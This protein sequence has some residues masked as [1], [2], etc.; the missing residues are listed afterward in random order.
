LGVSACTPATTRFRELAIDS[1]AQLPPFSPVL[2]QLMASLASPEVSFARLGALIEQDTVLT[3]NVLRL[4]NSALY[5][6]SGT[7][8]SVRA[9]VSILG[10]NR[11]RNY[12]FGLSVSNLWSKVKMPPGWDMG[13]FNRHALATALLADLIA[14]RSP[15]EYPEG[16]F[17]G[18]LLHDIGRLMIAVALPAEH[19]RIETLVAGR[20]CPAHEAEMEILG[21]THAEL[22]ADALHRWR[23]PAEIQHAVRF[24][25]RPEEL[26]SSTGAGRPALAAVLHA[27]DAASACLGFPGAASTA[28]FNA[29]PAAAFSPL[30]L[31]DDAEA[32]VTSFLTEWKMLSQTLN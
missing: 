26:A 6:R 14:Q 4:V 31:A 28:A 13:R 27:A 32:I 9:A 25:H 22:S 7:V 18:G 1:L 24:H 23:L 3:A 11:L 12:V 19:G 2:N 17:A 10:L 21:L 16:A 20:G 29:D 30:G 8:S 5:G 15:C